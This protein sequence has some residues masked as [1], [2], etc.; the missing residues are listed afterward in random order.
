MKTEKIK[1]ILIRRL[2]KLTEDERE[3]MYEHNHGWYNRYLF[4]YGSEDYSDSMWESLWLYSAFGQ[5]YL[6]CQVLA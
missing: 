1:E 3:W 4:E 6:H 2:N 5:C